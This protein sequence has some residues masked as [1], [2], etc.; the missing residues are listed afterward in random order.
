MRRAIAIIL[1]TLFLPQ[2]KQY[3][4]TEY[5]GF[6]PSSEDVLWEM[7]CEYAPTEY[8]A[9]GAMGMIY[10]ESRYK[11][12]ALCGWANIRFEDPTICEDFVAEVDAGLADGSSW[13]Y[14]YTKVHDVHGGFG[15]VTWVSPEYLERLYKYAQDWGTS[16]ADAEMQVSF[17][18]HDVEANDPELWET[19]CVSTSAQYCGEQFGIRYDRTYAWDAIGGFADQIYRRHHE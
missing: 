13:D 7:C 2:P 19:L 9:A 6:D 15:L 18:F 14:F 3:V 10:R 4:V 17:L 16:I 11:S 5:D 8:A 12:D 1:L